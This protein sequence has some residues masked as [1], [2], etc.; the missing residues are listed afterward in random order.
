M[1]IIDQSLWNTLFS[2]MSPKQCMLPEG[3][4][5]PWQGVLVYVALIVFVAALVYWFR[6]AITEYALIAWEKT[7]F[8]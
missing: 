8:S 7:P 4:I 1:V 6:D 5:L 3:C 2:W